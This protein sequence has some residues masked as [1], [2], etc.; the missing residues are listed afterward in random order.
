MHQAVLCKY[1][2]K[3]LLIIIISN[4]ICHCQFVKKQTNSSCI[5]MLFKSVSTLLLF[6]LME[7][8]WP[9]FVSVV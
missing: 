4:Q 8:Y 3:L 2:L 5:L 7:S 6:S 9:C 1:V